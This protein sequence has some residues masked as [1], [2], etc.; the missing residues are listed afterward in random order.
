MGLDFLLLE[1]L[2]NKSEQGKP[3]PKL[4]PAQLAL[5][6]THRVRQ[7]FIIERTATVNQMRA[8]MLE[9]GLTVPV[10]R[11][12]FERSQPAILEDA[13]NGLTDFIRALVLCLRER[14]QQLDIQIDEMS[15]MLWQASS[16]SSLC[17]KVSTVP[18]IGPIVSSAL[19]A[20]IGNGSQFKKAR[21]LSAWLGLVPRQYSTGGK[22]S[23]GG[24][25][26]RGNNYLRQ[27][28]IQGAKAL[29]IHMKCDKSS[30]GEW[31]ARLEVVHHHHV[32]LIALAN[33]IM[34]ICWKV[35][36]S[37]RDYQPYPNASAAV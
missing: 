13:E 28:V 24:I 20:A 34:R 19:I 32:V 18:G 7:R 37:G 26:Q 4:L 6:A 16:T 29:K 25:S 15:L 8:L 11:K 33:K 27:M 17:Q 23:L 14:W 31:V 9:Y 22:F 35:L 36:T 2:L 10:G 21:D 30:L 1:A 12:V 5:Q 3:F